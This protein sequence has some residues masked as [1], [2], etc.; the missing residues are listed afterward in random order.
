YNRDYDTVNRLYRLTATLT[1]AD[2]QAA[3][4]KYFVDRE[5]VVTTLAHG[6]LP[7]AIRTSPALSS[8]PE[9]AAAPA[10]ASPAPPPAPS[11]RASSAAPAPSPAA[12]L[13]FVRLPSPLPQLNVKLLFTVGSAGDPPGK[14]GLA[15]LAA[16]MIADAGSKE[17]RIDEINR[18]LFPMAGSFRAQVDKEMTTFTGSIH[19]DN[20]KA[21]FDVVLPQLVEPGYREE[22]F[23]R[24]KDVELAR[25]KE[26]LRSNNEEELAKERLQT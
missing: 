18:A 24:V 6:E 9:A 3:A 20:W 22:D 19:R 12:D 10:A 8:F 1:P 16:S 17:R 23:R 26:D 25:L 4:K 5:L 21:F 7:A 15:A 14:E 13:A 11:P 2:L